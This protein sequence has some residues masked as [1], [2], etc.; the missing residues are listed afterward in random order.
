MVTSIRGNR[1]P[2]LDSSHIVVIEDI[3]HLEHIAHPVIVDADPEPVWPSGV[4]KVGQRVQ[5]SPVRLYCQRANAELR[6][7]SLLQRGNDVG[8]Y[9]TQAKGRERFFFRSTK[10]SHE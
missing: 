7:L 6:Y 3:R 8:L 10:M 2:S 5:Q 1:V 4:T 9:N